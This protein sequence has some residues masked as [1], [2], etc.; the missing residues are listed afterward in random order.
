MW[1]PSFF[2][3]PSYVCITVIFHCTG[4]SHLPYLLLDGGCMIWFYL[5]AYVSSAASSM[6]VWMLFQTLPSVPLDMWPGVR[7]LD[8]V[9]QRK[10]RI[11]YYRSCTALRFYQECAGF[12]FLHILISLVAVCCIFWIV[13]I[14]MDM[15]WSPSTTFLANIIITFF[16][17]FRAVPRHIEVLRLGVQLE[18]QLP[19]YTTATATPDPSHVCHLYHSSQQHWIVNPLSQTRDRTRSLLVPS[20]ICFCCAT[21]GTA[22]ISCIL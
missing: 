13:A 19:A 4:V 14:I 20:W 10:L 16:F 22:H 21:M 17:L 18:L 9:K 12:Q 6:G 2:K 3:T 11:V 1:F 5:L 8:H 7:V 15:R